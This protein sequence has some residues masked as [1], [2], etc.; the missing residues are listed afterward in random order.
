MKII[1]YVN[2]VISVDEALSHCKSERRVELIH[3]GAQEKHVTIARNRESHTSRF[4]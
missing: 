4:Q 3:R 2:L 1:F